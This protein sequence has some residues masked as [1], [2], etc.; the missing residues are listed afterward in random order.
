[1]EYI[2]SPIWTLLELFAITIFA[3]AFMQKRP[4]K[5]DWLYHSLSFGR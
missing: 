5:S 3:D 2:I 1:M 4:A